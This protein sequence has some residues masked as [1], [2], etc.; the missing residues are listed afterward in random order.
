MKTS[1]SLL[2]SRQKCFKNICL[3]TGLPTPNLLRS[4]KPVCKFVVPKK[5]FKRNLSVK[6]E[7]KFMTGLIHV[8]QLKNL[9]LC[10]DK[11]ISK[12]A[13]E[14]LFILI[15]GLNVYSLDVIGIY[16]LCGVAIVW[17]ISPNAG[18]L[19]FVVLS[20]VA[21]YNLQRKPENAE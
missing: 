11:K 17:F 21:L 20:Y 9:N 18:T 7:K 10:V 15:L 5:L 3:F 13:Q 16:L 14:L 8:D 4:Y 6:S 1:R 2:C 19:L 12:V